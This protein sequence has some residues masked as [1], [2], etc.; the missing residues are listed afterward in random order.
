MS[1]AS[2]RHVNLAQTQYHASFHDS[3]TVNNLSLIDQAS[4]GGVA[5]E[6]VRVIFRANRTVDI[7]GIES[8]HVNNIG[9]G[10]VAVANTQKVPVIAIMHQYA[11]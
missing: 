7:K 4:N 3:L 8:H 2:S 10:T 6:Y 1:K 11:L 9:I 5:E